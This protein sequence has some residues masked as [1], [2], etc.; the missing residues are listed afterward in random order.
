[1]GESVDKPLE[2]Y[3]NNFCGTVAL[4]DIMKKHKCKNV[5]SS[6]SLMKPESPECG[7]TGKGGQLFPLSIELEHLASPHLVFPHLQMVF[8][9]SCTVYGIPEKT[10]IT[11]DTPLKAI[12]PYGRTKLFQVSADSSGIIVDRCESRD[13][14]MEAASSVSHPPLA[15][16]LASLPRRTCSATSA[17]VTQSGVSC[18]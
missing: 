3:Y 9:S 11:E 2:Y 5:R 12:S 4:L 17:S 6:M 13:D 14:A 8:S 15:A 7:D 16:P 18:C 10:P 1:V